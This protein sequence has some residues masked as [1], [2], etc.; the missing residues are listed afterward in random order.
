MMGERKAMDDAG[1]AAY[2][3]TL[4]SPT[5]LDPEMAAG[6]LVEVKRVF[7]EQ[8]VTFWLRSGTCLGGRS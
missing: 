5:P 7:D 4:A 8:G 2:L 1:E 6:R 3:K